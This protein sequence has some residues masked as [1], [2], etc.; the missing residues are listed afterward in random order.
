MMSA[1]DFFNE[2][3]TELNSVGKSSVNVVG[4]FDILRLLA[5]L[6]VPLLAHPVYQTPAGL[7][8]RMIDENPQAAES[9]G[10]S[11]ARTRTTAIVLG[12]ALARVVGP[13]PNKPYLSFFQEVHHC[14]KWWT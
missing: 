11:M 7:V 1:G 9:Q 12:S 10:I 2:T 13:A 6:L 5:L 4:S 3:D 8:L 14:E